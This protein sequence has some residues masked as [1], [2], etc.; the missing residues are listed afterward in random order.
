MNR[1][2]SDPNHEDRQIFFSTV[3][4]H[5]GGAPSGAAASILF[6]GMGVRAPIRNSERNHFF[7]NYFQWPTLRGGGVYYFLSYG[8]PS[9]HQ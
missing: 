9:P 2:G 7:E 6:A 5:R 8:A 3:L 1:S 4:I